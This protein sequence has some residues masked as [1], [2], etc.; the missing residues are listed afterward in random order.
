MSG[1]PGAGK[2][3]VA[4]RLAQHLNAPIFSIDPTEAAMWASG[5]AR[6]ETGIAAY[7][8]VQALAAENLKI[9]TSAIIDAVNPVE[10]ARDMWRELAREQNVPLAFIEVICSDEAIHRERIEAR[11]RGID[12]MDEVTW[13]HVRDRQREYESWNDERLKLDSSQM[14]PEALVTQALEYLASQPD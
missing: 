13:E 6:A 12:G 11:V 3:A 1:L 10:A 9:G 2:S 4:E 7:K 5:L 14:N 8:V